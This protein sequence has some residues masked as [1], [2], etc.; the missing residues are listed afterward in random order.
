MSKSGGVARSVF[1]AP[2]IGVVL[3]LVASYFLALVLGPVLFFFTAEGVEAG[4]RFLRALPVQLFG[5]FDFYVPVRLAWGSLFLFLWGVFVVCFVVSWGWRRSFHDVV[6]RAFSR[7]AGGLFDNWLFTMVV[8]ASMLLAGF[9]LITSLQNVVGVETGVPSLPENRFEAYLTL[10][11]AV[12]AEEVSFRISPI[13]LFLVVYLFLA[14]GNAVASMSLWRR[15]KLFFAAFLCPEKAKGMVGLRTVAANGLGG[16]ISL[17]EWVMVFVTALVF[18]LTHFVVGVGWGL[19]KI[20]TAFMNGFVFGLVYLA[21]G[22]QAPI[23]LH[24]FLNYYFYTYSL[25]AEFSPSLSS[26]FV[27]L[28]LVNLFL[29]LSAL[30]G[31]AL[32][33]LM[34]K[35]G[36]VSERVV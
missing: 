12:F 23:L 19:G 11:Y 14:G 35:L 33:A 10:A 13:G 6:G 36:A 27:V 31:F 28:E 22:F 2:L 32:L 9:V 7:S 29:G 16:G 4:G 26:V 8:V 20:S 15:V 30:L 3:F 24:W 5:V 1:L 25:A 21:Y 17:G 34:R 18:G